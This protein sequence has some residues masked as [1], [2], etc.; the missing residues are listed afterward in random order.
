MYNW[1]F[2]DRRFCQIIWQIFTQGRA[3]NSSKIAPS[4][5]WNQDLQIIRPMPYQL[6]YVNIQLLAWIFMAFIKSCSIDSRNEQ[7]PTCEVVHETK[8]GHFRNLL[9]NRFLPS[10]VGKALVWRSGGPGF[11]PHWGKILMKFILFCVTLDLSDNLT[12]TCIVKNSN[13]YIQYLGCRYGKNVLTFVFIRWSIRVYFYLSD[14]TTIF[15]IALVNVSSGGSRILRRGGKRSP[16][17]G[18]REDAPG[19]LRSASAKYLPWSLGFGTKFYSLF[20]TRSWIPFYFQRNFCLVYKQTLRIISL[21]LSS[22]GLQIHFKRHS[23]QRCD[24]DILETAEWQ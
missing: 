20:Q 2:H 24:K 16:S 9:P 4:G 17:N 5:V 23:G 11:K 6:S 14:K 22:S 18:G 7:S 8:K 19:P 21:W 10:S 15:W 12:E 3:K 1:V 13:V